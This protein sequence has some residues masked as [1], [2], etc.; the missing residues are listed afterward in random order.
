MTQTAQTPL[1]VSNLTKRFGNITAV[2]SLSFE[3]APN[4]VTGFLGPNGAGKTT[5]L[6]CILGLVNPSAGD[7]RIDGKSYSELPNPT[8]V[9][10]AALEA[11]GFHPGR[12]ARDTLRIRST[13]LYGSRDDKRI[14]E[15]LNYVGLGDAI[16]RKVGGY[17]LGMRQRLNLAMAL[18]GEPR[19]LILD[20]PGNGL[21]P[22]G[23]AWLRS[24][25]RGFATDGRSVLVSSHLLSEVKQS[26]DDVVI[27]DRGRL[28][29]A[30]SLAAL[31]DHSGGGTVSVLGP[32]L[33]RLQVVI[34]EQHPAATCQVEA[35]TPSTQGGASANARLVVTG[36]SAADVGHLAYTNNVELHGLTAQDPAEDLERLFLRLT[37]N[38][39]A[40]EDSQ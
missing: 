27:L 11:T 38:G 34:A 1:V 33:D 12:N 36:L 28:V 3:V 10:G 39:S 29:A 26:V 2:E 21:D 20:E 32:E 7:A 16:T 14:T 5:T 17:S 24:F 40:Q 18:I 35:N 6:R 15:L 19:M 13:V 37:G 25:M 30:D 8:A 23:I 22:A 4:R 31:L 9:V